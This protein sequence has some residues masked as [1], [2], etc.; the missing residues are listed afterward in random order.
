[1]DI[2]EKQKQDF[3]TNFVLA[4]LSWENSTFQTSES[5]HFVTIDV[6]DMTKLLLF[7]LILTVDL[8]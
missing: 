4:V 8:Y 7:F 3:D 2:H 6:K 5:K 1:M